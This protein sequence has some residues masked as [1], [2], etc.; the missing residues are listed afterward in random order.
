MPWQLQCL[1]SAIVAVSDVAVDSVAAGR[2]APV[3]GHVTVAT[4]APSNCILTNYTAAT[5]RSIRGNDAAQPP[6]HGRRAA[7]RRQ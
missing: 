1:D 2:R 3:N 7:G 5:G 4:V 6:S